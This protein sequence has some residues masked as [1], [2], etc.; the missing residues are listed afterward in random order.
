MPLFFV[1]FAQIG[2]IMEG[3]DYPSLSEKRLGL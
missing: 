3:A 2:W 1:P